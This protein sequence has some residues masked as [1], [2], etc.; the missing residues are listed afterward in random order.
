LNA[1][2]E[3]RRRSSGRYYSRRRPP[4]LPNI[5]RGGGYSG[6]RSYARQRDFT[7]SGGEQQP[8]EPKTEIGSYYRS[9]VEHYYS[10]RPRQA[11]PDIETLLEELRYSK[12]P[13]LLDEVTQRLNY[14][15]ERMENDAKIE[16]EASAEPIENTLSTVSPVQNIEHLEEAPS[17]I[18]PEHSEVMESSESLAQPDAVTEP[19]F[20][21]T[22]ESTLNDL[23]ALALELY[24]NPLETKVEES[25][26]NETNSY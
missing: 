3:K 12:D 4:Y 10:E 9:P 19:S 17:D 2:K 6:P 13:S 7:Y 16:V 15:T 1:Y 22:L 14:E 11:Q 20:T 24:A 8:R 5:N 25:V 21:E 18:S 23:D 26:E